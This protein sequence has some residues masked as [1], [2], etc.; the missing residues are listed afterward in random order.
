MSSFFLL[1]VSHLSG[2]APTDAPLAGYVGIAF[3]AS[4]L[5][6]KVGATCAV[7]AHGQT[8]SNGPPTVT[9]F[10]RAVWQTQSGARCRPL[11]QTPWRRHAACKCRALVQ[12]QRNRGL[13]QHAQWLAGWHAQRN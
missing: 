1:I 10:M 6:R 7:L 5:P 8:C 13:A 4:F 3:T 9:P 12:S 11:G 2:Y